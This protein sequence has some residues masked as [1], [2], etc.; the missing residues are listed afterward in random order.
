MSKLPESPPLHNPDPPASA[1]GSPFPSP[2]APPKASS[3]GPRSLPGRGT[4]GSARPFILI[5]L[6]IVL[7][8]GLDVAAH[9]ATGKSLLTGSVLGPGTSDRPDAILHTVKRESLTVTVTA[10]GQVESADNKDIVCKVRAGNKGYATSINWVIDDGT[11]VKPGQLL[12]ILDDSALKDQEDQQSITVKTKMADKVKAE[13]DYEITLREN[14]NT[15]SLAEIELDKLTGFA[16]DP[17]RLAL[18]AVGGVS[19]SLVEGGSY[20]QE[21]DDLTG[22]ISLAQSNV[23]QYRERVVWADRMVKL[24]YMAPAQAQAEKSKLDS[25][26]EDL[27]SKE[28][29]KRLL[30]DYDRRQRVTDLTSKRDTARLKAE[31][32][33]YQFRIAKQTATDVYM[34]EK[35]KLDDIRRQRAECKIY[36][37]DEIL[38]G[39]MVVYFKPEGG[40]FGQ[41]SSQGLIEHG[42]QVKE[43]QKMLRIPNLSS[44]QVNAKV[45]EAMVSR[46]KGEVRVPTKIAEG[47][48]VRLLANPFFPPP[49][50]PAKRALLEALREEFRREEYRKI[51]DGQRATIK[52]SSLA[53]KQFIGHVRSRAA[54]AS[55]ADWSQ[56]DV[57]MY[58][59]FIRIDG[60]L[61]L[62]GKSIIPLESEVLWPDMTAVVIISVDAAKGPVLTAPIQ[63][64]VG[65]VEMGGTRE[66]FVKTDSG[67]DRR[68]VD[69]GLYNETMVEIRSGLEEGDVIVTNPKVLLGEGEKTKTRDP[70]EFKSTDPK[71][72]GKPGMPGGTGVPGGTG[73]PTKKGGKGGKGGFPGGEGGFP[74]GGAP[75]GFSPPGA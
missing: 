61:G 44:M 75:G 7:L 65:G 58:Q 60:E 3:A 26:V 45:N 66:I 10:K 37:P 13:K 17:A 62:D 18:A 20:K 5:G 55:Q 2:S 1:N 68:K 29:K 51:A 69:L 47:W 63:S 54:V 59:T 35:E 9:F 38:D 27:R 22:Q 33:E 71:G 49:G 21:L 50:E 48:L 32:L 57:K 43:G 42:A 12:M 46:I 74:K 16:P 36:A 67:Y 73:E 72:E 41:S 11:R 15:L 6:F 53:D 39:S 24:S 8:I 56:S 25:S 30:Q 14:E 28:A 52:L 40:R 23:E 19:S 4:R 64:V 34:Q 31:A 70:G